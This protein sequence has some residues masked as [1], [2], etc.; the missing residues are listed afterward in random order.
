VEDRVGLERNQLGLDRRGGADVEL[1]VGE[2]VDL[3]LRAGRGEKG[4]P[5]PACGPGDG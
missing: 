5:E 4:A 2:A 3:M 1:V